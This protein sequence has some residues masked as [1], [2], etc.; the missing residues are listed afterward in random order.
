MFNE[1]RTARY[2]GSVQS[3]RGEIALVRQNGTGLLAQFDNMGLHHPNLREDR[4]T[5]MDTNHGMRMLGYGW[6]AFAAEEFEI[7]EGSR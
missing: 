4:V 1:M 5:Y 6:T 7:L 2:I 3:L